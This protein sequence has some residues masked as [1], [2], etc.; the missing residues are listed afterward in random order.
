[1][2]VAVYTRVSSDMQLEGYSLEAQLA[3]C[4]RLADERGWE[5]VV[6]YTDEGLS[7]KTTARPR[8]RAMMRDARFHRFDV[9]IVHKLDRLSRSVVD[10]LTV[11]HELEALEVLWHALVE[12]FEPGD[13]L[14]SGHRD[15]VGGKVGV[16]S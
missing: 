7:A 14:L 13:G 12:L 5:I 9:V 10:L 11:L 8:F 1:M 4:Q 16:H 3:A 2:K 6:V 15:G